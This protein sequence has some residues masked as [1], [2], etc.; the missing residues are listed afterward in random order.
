MCELCVQECEPGAIT[1]GSK[2]DAFL[3]KVESTGALSPEAIV[4]KAA[5]ILKDRIRVS[6]DFVGKL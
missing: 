1:I 3:F 5:S 6:L 2:N 4:E